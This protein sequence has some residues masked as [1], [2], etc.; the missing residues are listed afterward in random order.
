M[1]AALTIEEKRRVSREIRGEIKLWLWE[2][3]LNCIPYSDVK[4]AYLE[5]FPE[6]RDSAFYNNITAL[7]K[8]IL[9]S[10]ET[11][12]NAPDVEQMRTVSQVRILMRKSQFEYAREL[13]KKCLAQSIELENFSVT[14]MLISEL[15]EIFTRT[16]T[17]PTKVMAKN[18]LKW[19]IDA[20]KKGQNLAE[21]QS[22]F[23]QLTSVSD[24]KKVVRI[25]DKSTLLKIGNTLSQRAKIYSLRCKIHL[26]RNRTTIFDAQNLIGDLIQLC[27][28]VPFGYESEIRGVYI[29]NVSALSKMHLAS[30]NIQQAEH[31]THSLTD[32]FE[33]FPSSRAKYWALQIRIKYL[34]GDAE[35]FR[36]ECAKIEARFEKSN[37]LFNAIEVADLYHSLCW[38]Y[39]FLGEEKT[40]LKW[41]FRLKMH[42]KS[43]TK[44]TCFALW[45][46]IFLQIICENE[47]IEPNEIRRAKV[48]IERNSQNSKYLVTI[49]SALGKFSGNLAEW[50]N[51]IEPIVSQLE[52]QE[53][54]SFPLSLYIR[55]RLEKK[56]FSEFMIQSQD[57]I[58]GY[59]NMPS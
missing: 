56:P 13:A 34:R 14:Q 40:A 59:N 48:W 55:S 41:V 18:L 25:A 33:S 26:I 29:R 16:R 15:R 32:Y 31:L 23:M 53:D 51:L 22:L 6:S 1:I 17:R 27:T 12:D 44:L 35:D 43:H 21:F 46:S 7:R 50:L 42:D 49:L 24:P 36:T 8:T 19:E 57:W 9:N 45:F 5:N 30:G 28:S 38:Y 37:H 20:Q 47:P 3:F 10:L 39:L 2:Q 11:H 54:Q 58:D 4:T 52:N